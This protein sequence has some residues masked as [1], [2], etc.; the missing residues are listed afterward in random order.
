MSVDPAHSLSDA[1]DLSAEGLIPRQT[2]EPLELQNNLWIQEVDIGEEINRNWDQIYGYISTLLSTT[3][4]EEILAEEMAIFPGMEELS[5]FLHINRYVR[6]KA[7]DAIILDCA[8]TGESLRFVSIPATLEWYMRKLFHLERRVAKVA[9]PV[10]RHFTD[11]PLPDD[12]YFAALERLGAN[13]RTR[14]A[15]RAQH[16][17]HSAALR[18]LETH[19]PLRYAAGTGD[20][21]HATRDTQHVNPVCFEAPSHYEL[22]AAD[23]R[24]LVGSA[25][26]RSSDAVLQHGAL[27]L[28]GDIA[29]ICR[30]LADPPEPERVRARA[31]TLESALGRWVG[32]QE[33]AEAMVTGFSTALSLTLTPGEL[34]LEEQGWVVELR[35]EKYANDAWTWRERDQVSGVNQPR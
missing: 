1:F 22:V 29:R 28:T 14:N 25:Q 31:A 23:G 2:F 20:T 34:A 27:P 18:G 6:D 19:I 8:P 10:V 11:V 15:Q 5:C 12:D 33:A 17:S 4:I 26:M 13:T 32:W 7:F 9:R 3:G 16:G 21:Q 24:K 35:A 30:Y